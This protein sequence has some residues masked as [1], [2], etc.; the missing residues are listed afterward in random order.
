MVEKHGNSLGAVGLTEFSQKQRFEKMFEIGDWR[1]KSVL[2]VGCGLGHF[3]DFLDLKKAS[4]DVDYTGFD[5]SSAM[6][7]YARENHPNIAEKFKVADFLT[8]TVSETFDYIIAGGILNLP[9]D[10]DNVD[11][12]MKLIGKM[13]DTCNTGIAI[14]MTS[15][16]SR[17]QNEATF[18]YNPSEILDKVSAFCKNLRLD[19]SYM[20]HDFTLFCYK[21]DLYF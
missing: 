12:T 9:L 17:K 1:G 4:G 13:Y 8:D 15:D 10:G 14:S 19:H 2:D 7:Q 16:Y 11:V 21:K 20:P 18:Y 6:I 3:Y 5:I